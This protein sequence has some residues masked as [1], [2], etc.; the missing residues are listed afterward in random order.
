MS[1][2]DWTAFDDPKFNPKRVPLFDAP[3]KRDMAVNDGDT[4]KL[5]DTSFKL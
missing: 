3:P 2:T 4:L 5:G 1:D